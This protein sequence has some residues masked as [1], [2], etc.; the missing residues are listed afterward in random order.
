MSTV[1]PFVVALVVFVAIGLI[2]A[3]ATV[4]AVMRDGYGTVPDRGP[5]ARRGFGPAQ[6]WDD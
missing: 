5:A 4:V 2:A 3:A 6:R 1:D